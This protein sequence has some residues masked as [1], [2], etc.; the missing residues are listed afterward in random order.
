[1]KT[2]TAPLKV[3]EPRWATTGQI[4][5]ICAL[6]VQGVPVDQLTFEVATAILGNKGDFLKKLVALFPDP[7]IM[8]DPI[9]Q[10]EHFYLTIFG[11]TVDFSQVKIPVQMDGFTRLIFVAKE[12]TM[13]G[14]YDACAKRF[15]CWP[16]NDDLDAAVTVNDRT[17][18]G[19]YAI[20]VR[21]TVEADENLK[22]LSADDIKK[23]KIVTM[24]LLE[25]ML[26]ELKWFLETGKH[27]D[28]GNVTLC[29]GSRY[30]GGYVPSADWRDGGFGI[31]W[32]DAG[33]CNPSLR[34]RQAVS[35]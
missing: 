2:E 5:D 20:W 12:L 17:P 28:V 16:Y 7:V 18:T 30:S 13:N 34:A 29:A 4:K 23:Q 1:M 6:M 24:T 8:A 32:Y 10:W 19:G 15:K 22:D 31:Y 11:L 9:K 27:L 25:R 3:V 21:D 35:L 14:V 33:Y 26:Y